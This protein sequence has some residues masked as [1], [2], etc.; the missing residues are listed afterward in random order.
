MPEDL[1]LEI[2]SLQGDAK[3]I[4]SNL[5]DQSERLK[6]VEADAVDKATIQSN[7]DALDEKLRTIEQLQAR[8][9]AASQ[10]KEEVEVLEYFNNIKEKTC[11]NKEALDFEGMKEYKSA[12]SNFLAHGYDPLN[13]MEKKSLNS[14][15]DPQGGYLVIPQYSADIKHI[16]QFDAYGILNEVNTMTVSGH[17]EQ[18]LDKKFYDDAYFNTEMTVVDYDVTPDFAKAIFNNREMIV[19]EKFSRTEL[20]DSA[21]PVESY[22]VSKLNAGMAYKLAVAVVNGDGTKGLRGMLSYDSGTAFGQVERLQVGTTGKCQITDIGAVLLPSLKAPY[23]SGA[24][25]ALNRD[26][27]FKALFETTTDGKLQMSN[28][29]NFFGP[30]GK[31]QYTFAGVPVVFDMSLG[32]ATDT[33]GTPI[34]VYGDFKQFYLH[35]K[36]NAVSVVRDETKAEYILLQL[37]ER[38]DGKVMNFEAAKILTSK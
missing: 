36:T 26:T 27:Y 30:D 35:T 3:A 20:E 25:L 17:Y 11:R 34:A 22:V 12:F 29:I 32:K 14:L 1:T 2:K 37:R 28:I 8:N 9:S 33:A 5:E 21:Y 31:I 16:N 4:M 6:K 23:A 13:E 24:K 15:S 7:I 10:S 19:K 18:A 38:H